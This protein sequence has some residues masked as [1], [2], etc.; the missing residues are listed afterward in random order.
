M[1]RRM[2]RP[3]LELGTYGA[4][5]CYK[6]D[7]GYRARTLARDYDG[8]VRGTERRAKGKA[9]AELALKLALRDRSRVQ[10]E[11]DITRETRV[12]ALARLGTPD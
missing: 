6:T 4:I 11:G 7:A 10:S 9:A 5:R 2:G 12:S 8:Q 3:P 1:A